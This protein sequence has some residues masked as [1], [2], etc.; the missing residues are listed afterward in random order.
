MELY[1]VVFKGEVMPGLSAAQVRA[2][3]ARLFNSL[4]EQLDNLFDGQA[5]A[6][7]SGLQR[8]EAERYHQALKSA[9]AISY[10]RRAGAQRAVAK[11]PATAPAKPPPSLSLA[12]RK[13]N[14][15]HDEERASVP[16]LEIDTQHL[17]LA[18]LDSGPLAP[19][20]PTPPPAPNTD[21][22]QLS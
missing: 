3:L 17:H 19:A 12:P 11:S 10:L 16:P 20:K 14:L 15:L 7:K 1:D 21:H 5:H 4:P 6:L 13:G 2:D 18:P 22:I 8:N 9:G